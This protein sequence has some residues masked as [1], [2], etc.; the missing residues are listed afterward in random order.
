M[1]GHARGSQA[2][3]FDDEE[4]DDEESLINEKTYPRKR[5]SAF[6]DLNYE[7]FHL[8]K[9][10]RNSKKFSCSITPASCP[11]YLQTVDD[12]FPNTQSTMYIFCQLSPFA[13][14]S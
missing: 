12:P 4:L 9:N 2:L 8:V 5:F 13:Q 7:A 1:K 11:S 3:S 10:H 6:K 14:H